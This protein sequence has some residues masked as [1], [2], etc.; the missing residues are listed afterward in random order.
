MKAQTRIE[1]AR[2]CCPYLGAYAESRG[3]VLGRFCRHPENLDAKGRLRLDS[4]SCGEWEACPRTR[5]QLQ[6]SYR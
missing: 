4:L 6:R 5:E 1:R 3:I 2:E